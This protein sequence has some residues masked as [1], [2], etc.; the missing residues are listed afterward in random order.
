MNHALASSISDRAISLQDGLLAKKFDAMGRM[1]LWH[2]I[3]GK[4]NPSSI[5]DGLLAMRGYWTGELKEDSI[6]SYCRRHKC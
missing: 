6:L 5:C 3:H 1:A 2:V 4:S